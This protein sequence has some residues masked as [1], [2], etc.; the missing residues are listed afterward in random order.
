MKQLL[1]SVRDDHSKNCADW[2]PALIKTNDLSHSFTSTSPCCRQTVLEGSPLFSDKT[3]VDVAT[4]LHRV[5]QILRN[6]S[7]LNGTLDL[8]NCLWLVPRPLAFRALTDSVLIVLDH[9]IF[10]ESAVAAAVI[11]IAATIFDQHVLT[12]RGFCVPAMVS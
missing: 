7:V 11:V 5:S 6:D 3:A 9:T 8:T 10:L 2:D 1:N 12:S 4:Q